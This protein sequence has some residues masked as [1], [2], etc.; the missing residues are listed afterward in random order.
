MITLDIKLNAKLMQNASNS[1][2]FN[3]EWTGKS[4]GVDGM[5]WISIT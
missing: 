5:T 3:Q 4:Q 1:S 2:I